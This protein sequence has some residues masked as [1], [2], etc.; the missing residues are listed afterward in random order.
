MRLTSWVVRTNEVVM[1]NGY[2]LLRAVLDVLHTT[3]MK[4]QKFV[5]ELQANARSIQTRAC[6]ATAFLP[7]GETSTNYYQW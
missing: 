3:R 5:I 7:T 6:I 2:V 1:E 4:K